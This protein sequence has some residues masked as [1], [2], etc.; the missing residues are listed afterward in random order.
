MFRTAVLFWLPIKIDEGLYYNRIF[1][2]G[3][4]RRSINNSKTVANAKSK[5]IY[6]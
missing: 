6:I 3:K 5:Q 4:E 2:Y 1:I